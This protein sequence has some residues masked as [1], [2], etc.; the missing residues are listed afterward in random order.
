MPS[1][2]Q[3]ACRRGLGYGVSARRRGRLRDHGRDGSPA[4][5]ARSRC[6]CNTLPTGAMLAVLILT[7]GRVSGAHFNPAVSL[8][9]RCAARC[10]GRW[11]PPTSARKFVGGHRRRLGRPPDVRAAALASFDNGRTGPGQWLAE[12]VAT[13][14]LLLTIFGCVRARAGGRA[15]CG[16]PLHYRGLLVHGVDVVRQSGRDDRAFALRYFR[17]HRAGRRRRLHRC[18]T[19]RYAGGSDAQPLAVGR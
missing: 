10:R 7:F 17:R 4:E 9:S 6:L 5:T 3:R 12:A 14:G 18:A 13:F 16:W 1:L 8:A 2:A 19:C 11:R 15:L